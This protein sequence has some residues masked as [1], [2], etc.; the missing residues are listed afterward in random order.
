MALTKVSYSMI[1]GAPVNVLDYGAVADGV[2]DDWAAIMAAVNS[3]ARRI[4][5]PAGTYYSTKCIKLLKNTMLEGVNGFDAGESKSILKFGNATLGVIVHSRYTNS[6]DYGL[7]NYIESTPRAEGADGSIVKYLTIQRGDGTAVTPTGLLHGVRMRARAYVENCYIQGFAGSGIYIYADG[8]TT[9]PDFLGNAN[10]F[11]VTN[12]YVRYCQ[13][14]I[15]VDG[16]DTNVGCILH[17]NFTSN[18]Q[19]G[20]FES[21]ALGCSYINCHCAGNTTNDIKHE[22]SGNRSTFIGQYV[23]SGGSIAAV[24]P[25]MF[26]SGQ[27]SGLTITGDALVFRSS[28]STFPQFTVPLQ[29]STAFCEIQNPGAS[30]TA[31][32]S[33]GV[34]NQGSYSSTRNAGMYLKVGTTATNNPVGAFVGR[35]GTSAITGRSAVSLEIYDGTTVA[36]E[37]AIEARGSVNDIIPGT[38]NQWDLGDASFRYKEIFAV[39]GTINTSDAR[40]KQDVENLN[41]AEKRVAIAIKGLVKKFRFKDAVAK[42]GDNARIHIGV[43]AQEVMA[44]FQA[45]NLDPTRYGIVCYD[46]WDADEDHGT[47]AG[48]RYGIRYEQLLAF[49]IA[50]I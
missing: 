31:A 42:K 28:S 40:E 47:L 2:T 3:G 25:A 33:F 7:N 21:S 22:G 27:L 5:F 37:T 48:N 10:N 41:E 15:F 43:V 46:E 19:Y 44:A 50:A 11:G 12:T 29:T 17:G 26:F 1:T 23:E 49:V 38:D 30:T 13:N 16:P 45:E 8:T 14:G 39:N 36:Y 32:R 20:I 4:Y 24:F 34:W 6:D 9:T 35:G 18:Q